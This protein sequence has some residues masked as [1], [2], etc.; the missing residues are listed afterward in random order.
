MNADYEKLVC[1]T[2]IVNHKFALTWGSTCE[3]L[4]NRSLKYATMGPLNSPPFSNIHISPILAQDKPD[5]GVHFI[6]D[7]SLPTCQDINSCIDSNCHDN[8]ELTLKYPTID[9]LV[10]QMLERFFTSANVKNACVTS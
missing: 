5:V 3:V 9:H 2:D 8:I 6:V 7:L 10:Q 1:N 4:L